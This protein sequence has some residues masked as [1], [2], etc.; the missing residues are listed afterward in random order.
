[1]YF[2]VNV[3]GT[4]TKL[5]KPLG[6]SSYHVIKVL[7]QVQKIPITFIICV[8]VTVTKVFKNYLYL[9]HVRKCVKIPKIL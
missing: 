5:L 1:M 8:T 4:D 3:M 9:K 7:N 2:T 6:L